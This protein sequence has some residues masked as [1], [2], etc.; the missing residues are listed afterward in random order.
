MI[1]HTLIRKFKAKTPI[2]YKRIQRFCIA[3]SSVSIIALSFKESLPSYM[4]D[5]LPHMLTIGL[6]GSLMSQFAE[7]KPKDG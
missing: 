2:V 5:L 7:E 3:M 1:H 6:L 4:L